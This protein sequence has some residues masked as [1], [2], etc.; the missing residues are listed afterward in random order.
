[1]YF[2]DDSMRADIWSEIERLNFKAC[3][4][5]RL[6]AHR[7]LLHISKQY[8][9]WRTD[10]T[11]AQEQIWFWKKN[12]HQDAEK[13][14][15]ECDRR[16]WCRDRFCRKNC[17]ILNMKICNVD[18]NSFV[19]FRPSLHDW[20]TNKSKSCRDSI[21]DN[22]DDNYVSWSLRNL[23]SVILPTYIDLNCSTRS[24]STDRLL[25][26]IDSC[27]LSRFMSTVD[28]NRLCVIR[29]TFLDSRHKSRVFQVSVKAL[30]FTR[31]LLC[32]GLWS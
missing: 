25:F 21:R 32:S 30:T 1:M 23:L 10:R 12:I 26:E 15:E 29:S 8:S 28:L 24:R 31:D 14:R 13:E 11:E 9:H 18:R 27:R 3:S 22:Y 19:I 2:C 6:I 7:D 5:S 4:S 16:R 20:L 17:N